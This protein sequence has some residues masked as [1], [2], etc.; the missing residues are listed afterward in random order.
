MNKKIFIS[1]SWKDYSDVNDIDSVFSRFGITLIRD[2]R[3]LKYNADIRNFM[4]KVKE[5]DKIIIYV[6]NS[7][8]RSVNCMYEA[9]QVLSVKEKVVVILKEDTNVFS[10]KDKENL[11]SYWEKECRI[12]GEKDP[13]LFKNEIEDTKIACNAISDFVD[14]V[15]KSKRMSPKSL[16]FDDLLNDLDVKREYPIIITKDVLDW[17]YTYPKAK[18]FD[19]LSLINDLYKSTRIIFSE[20]PNIP[21]NEIEYKF[22]KIEFIRNINGINL[23]LTVQNIKTGMN[24]NYTF[25]NLVQV[26]ENKMRSEVHSKYYFYCENSYKKQRYKEMEEFSKFKSLTGEEIKLKSEGYLDVFRLTINFGVN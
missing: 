24:T 18:L 14:F 8:L 2:I 17:I 12:I 16:S 20:F 21:D 11:I 26:E 22:I 3:D 15:K 7:Y 10:V 13:A 4:Q 5:H 9:S 25:Y 1:Y 23:V 6:T 19:V